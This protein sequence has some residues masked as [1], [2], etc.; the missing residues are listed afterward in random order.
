[1][2]SCVALQQCCPSALL[3]C[4]KQRLVVTKCDCTQ[5]S[6]ERMKPEITIEYCPKCG[7]LL[8]A[9]YI[10]QELLTTFADE[11]GAVT[12]RPSETAG[13]FTLYCNKQLL[14]D[15]KQNGGF[16]D[17][18]EIKQLIRDAIAPQKSLGHSDR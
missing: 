5:K 4:N 3:A 17:S 9:A 14:F 11:L 1:M 7:W 2:D 15:R 18:K 10:A 12:L 6:N 16:A 13:R 8:R